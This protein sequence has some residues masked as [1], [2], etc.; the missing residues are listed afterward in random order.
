MKQKMKGSAIVVALFFLVS[1]VII[2]ASAFAED[3]GQPLGAG[4]QEADNLN[5]GGL[6]GPL[7]PVVP[8]GGDTLF[9]TFLDAFSGGRLRT[10]EINPRDLGFGSG[11]D[12]YV[13]INQVRS[14]D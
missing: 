13:P 14:V 7:Q 4:F 2:T 3:G 1:I 10:G 11:N 9:Y 6:F 8:V 12:K 5:Y